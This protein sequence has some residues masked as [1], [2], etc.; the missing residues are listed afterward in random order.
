LRRNLARA[1][2]INEYG[3]VEKDEREQEFERF[4]T[5]VGYTILLD[6]HRP[7]E[8]AFARAAGVNLSKEPSI[9]NGKLSEKIIWR[10]LVK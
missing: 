2:F 4:L 1:Y 3:A 9:Y 10:D 6:I 7:E 8:A 5:S